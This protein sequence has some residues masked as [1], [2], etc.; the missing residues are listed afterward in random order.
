[1]DDEP[2]LSVEETRRLWEGLASGR[3]EIAAQFDRDGRRFLVLTTRAPRPLSAR[4]RQ[5]TARAA[6]GHSNKQIAF[7]LGVRTSTVGGYLRT[8]ATKLGVT[9]RVALIAAY[10]ET[11]R[12]RG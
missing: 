1:M 10:R 3:W 4:E 2:P 12:R 6:L 5:V 8:A 11:R 9:T 7:D